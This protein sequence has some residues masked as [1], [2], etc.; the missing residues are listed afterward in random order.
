MFDVFED[1]SRLFLAP[2]INSQRYGVVSKKPCLI[3]VSGKHYS[4]IRE[5]HKKEHSWCSHFY[6]LLKD[7]S[8]RNGFLM[9]EVNPDSVFC[10][11]FGASNFLVP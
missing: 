6:F 11:F 8:Q 1:L 10:W 2:L 5:S 7:L 9:I 3:I 4:L